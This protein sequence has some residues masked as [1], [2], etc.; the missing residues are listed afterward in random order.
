MPVPYTNQ[1]NSGVE[2]YSYD[3]TSITVR[4][5]TGGTYRYTFASC[6]SAD[7]LAMQRLADDGVKLC[8]YINQNK[9]AYASKTTAAKKK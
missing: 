6:G 4:F 7:V 5:H 2:G 9:P 8:T 3:A 1:A